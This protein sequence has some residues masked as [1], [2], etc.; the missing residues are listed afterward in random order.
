MPE[1]G[2]D[3]AVP[4]EDMTGLEDFEESDAV[5]PRLVIEHADAVLKDSLTNERF[6]SLEVIILGLVKQRILWDVEVDEGDKPLCKSFDHDHGRPDAANF[7][8]DH[9]PFNRSDFGDDPTLDCESCP[10]K[11]WGSHPKRD[12]P[13]C[14]EQFVLPVVVPF[15]EDNDTGAAAILTL[16]RSS[17]KPARAYI[18]G[19]ARSQTPLFTVRTTIRLDGLKRGSVTYAVPEFTKG[20]GTDESMW[21]HFAA[22]YRDIRTFVSTE[23]TF[24]KDAPEGSEP[25]AEPA[26]STTSSAAPSGVDDEPA[27]ATS[28]EPE[29]PTDA[30]PP[31]DDDIPF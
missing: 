23:R 16:Q 4:V 10:L 3:L 27:P 30:P 13:W 21:A 11:E 18:S 8:W 22:Q 19:F 20:N 5:I 6:E 28:A 14:T 26:S 25:T 7:P 29:A 24:G 31:D 2:T 12:T 1:P 9:T 15:S 17:L